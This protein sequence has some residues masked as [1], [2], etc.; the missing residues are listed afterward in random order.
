MMCWCA[1]K[2]HLRMR[3]LPEAVAAI[4]AMPITGI[5]HFLVTQFGKPFTSAGFGNWFRERCNDAGLPQCSAH[6][7]RKAMSR[8][9]AESG[10][11]TLQG[12]AVTGHKTDR[13]FS[14]YAENANREGLA[15]DA[16]ATLQ[17]HNLVR[18]VQ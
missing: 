8:K 15:D 5:G 11:T 9:L 16:M 12:R 2:L 10:A 1:F 7:L 3:A 17:A 6:G 13:M 4:E 18:K 14:Y